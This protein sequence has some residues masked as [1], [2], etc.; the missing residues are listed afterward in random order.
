MFGIDV[1]EWLL[2]MLLSGCWCCYVIAITGE[3]LLLLVNGDY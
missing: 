3:W 2:S 1:G